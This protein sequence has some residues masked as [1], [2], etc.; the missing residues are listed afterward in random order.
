MSVEG[1]FLEMAYKRTE[2]EEGR[3]IDWRCATRE[4]GDEEMW[5]VVCHR[6]LRWTIAALRGER[7]KLWEVVRS[8]GGGR[9]RRV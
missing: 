7:W 2:G 8:I 9:E 6:V 5:V 1:T 3:G 4:E